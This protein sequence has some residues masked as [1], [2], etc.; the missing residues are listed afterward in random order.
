[1]Y[2]YLFMLY[3]FIFYLF[4]FYLLFIYF[5]TIYDVIMA[6]AVDAGPSQVPACAKSHPQCNML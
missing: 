5:T 1:M 2:L 4:I 3:L 6:T